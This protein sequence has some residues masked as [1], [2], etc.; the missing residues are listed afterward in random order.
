MSPH[1]HEVGEPAVIAG[2]STTTLDAAALVDRVRRDDCG[3]LV[4]FEGT[5]RTPN[6]GHDVLAL[7]Y[8]AWEDRTPAQ[9]ERI[10]GEVARTHVLHAAVGMHRVGSV[11]VGDTA[12]VV[13]A[14]APHR[15]AAF[16]G[17]R[18]LIDRIKSEAWIWKKELRADGEVWI[19]GC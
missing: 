8:E 12:V 16:A 5:T 14:V 18:E 11:A 7:D 1:R 19:E 13:I 15:D 6:H 9:L 4:V 3:G 17:A 10:V 2:L